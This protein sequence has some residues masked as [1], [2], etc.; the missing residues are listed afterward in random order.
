MPL[1]QALMRE[2]DGVVS[3]VTYRPIDLSALSD[4]VLNQFARCEGLRW[5]WA[6]L[7]GAI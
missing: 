5:S 2:T 4:A 7:F 1:A 3:A 6:L